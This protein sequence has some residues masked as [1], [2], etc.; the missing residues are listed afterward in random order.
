MIAPSS[1]SASTAAVEYAE[2]GW[3]MVCLHRPTIL[4]GGVAKCS[5]GDDNCT[6]QGKH[7]RAGQWTKLATTDVEVVRSW[8]KK[9]PLS[10]VGVAL[11]S[12]SGIVSIDVDPP[13]GEAALAA[14]SG[15]DLPATLELTTGKG[16]SLIYS[17]PDSLPSDPRTQAWKDASGQE[18]IRLQGTGS[19]RVLPPSLHPAG[20]HYEWVAGHG[21]GEIEAAPMPS[22]LIVEMCRPQQAAWS[23]PQTSGPTDAYAPGAE[24][25]KTKDWAGLLT[26]NGWKP[27]GGRGA[28]TYWTRPGKT[29]GV[30]ATV[31][32]YNA[33]DGTP[34]LYVFTGN[35][36][37]LMAG[38]CYDLFGA[39]ARLEHHGD[40]SAAASALTGRKAKPTANGKATPPKPADATPATP[41]DEPELDVSSHPWPDPLLPEALHGIA[42]EIVRAIEPHTEADPAAILFQFL[43]GFG[44]MVGRQAYYRVESSRHYANLFTVLV[45]QSAR[46]RKG[47]SWARARWVLHRGGDAQWAADRIVSGLSSGEGVVYNVRD[48]IMKRGK[49][50]ADG[51]P[52]KEEQVDS[53]IDDKRLLVIEEEFASVLQVGK[54]EGNILGSIL[55]SAWDTGNLGSLTKN[56]P[57]RAT[58]AHISLISHITQ[59]ELL[60]TI[61]STQAFNGFLNRFLW[62]AVRRSKLLPHGGEEIDMDQYSIRVEDAWR[63]ANRHPRELLMDTQARVLWTLEYPRLTADR[64][65]L[66]GAI[67]SRAEAQ[68]IRLALIYALLDRS[69]LITVTHLRAGLA[70][71]RY[72]SQSARH[73]FGDATGDPVADEIRALLRTNPNG[74]TQTEISAHFAHHRSKVELARAMEV[75]VKAGLARSEQT[76]TAGR[77]KVTWRSCEISGLS[78][79]RP[80][81]PGKTNENTAPT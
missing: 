21:P 5:C 33:K 15:G 60:C 74:A 9:H 50:L 68:V 43:T 62:A 13:G 34:A 52:G 49:P 77:P 30:S 32:H 48:K 31:G 19:Q 56:S 27:A 18:S 61:A 47:T 3:R 53:G 57:L 76:P 26:R 75:L 66:F 35:A 58:G 11:G 14:V 63:F 44:N 40:F 67:T 1:V 55:R 2:R 8:W 36:P 79:G 54:R 24:Y 41:L 6:S 65:G 73:I 10:N 42:G 22:W 25:N 46:A 38:K 7:P 71:E 28:V 23:D 29:G 17:I 59:H 20:K 45:G 81:N 51:T 64:S 4:V 72:V 80:Q 70:I 12:G 78:E 69:D 39:Y 37:H 16:R